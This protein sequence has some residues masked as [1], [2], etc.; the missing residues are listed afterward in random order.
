MSRRTFVLKTNIF[1][2][3]TLRRLGGAK[4]YGGDPWSLK[5]MGKIV[6]LAKGIVKF[7]SNGFFARF[8]CFQYSYIL[9]VKLDQ[10]F[11]NFQENPALFLV[12]KVET[13]LYV[14]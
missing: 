5:N 3:L 12:H 11:Q 6:H 4:N 10:T 14:H 8:T 1:Y 9:P 2:R 7:G 13:I